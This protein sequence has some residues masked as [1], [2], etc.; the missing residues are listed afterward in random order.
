MSGKEGV[1]FD[2]PMAIGILDAMGMDKSA[3]QHLLVGEL[4]LDGALLPVRAGFSPWG[5]AQGGAVSRM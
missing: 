4:S 1:G 2:L 5:R 3:D